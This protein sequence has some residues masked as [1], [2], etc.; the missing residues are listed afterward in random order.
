MFAADADFDVGPRLPSLLHRHLHQ[1]SHALA[2]QHLE[3]IL[4]EDL[5]LH[6]LKE[7][8]TLRVVSRKPEGRLGQIISTKGEELGVLSYLGMQ[9][10]ETQRRPIK[11]SN[12]KI[13]DLY[14][15]NLG[16]KATHDDTVSVV[17]VV[18]RSGAATVQDVL[19]YP[20]EDS[21]LS[22]VTDMIM[23]AD[24]RPASENGRAV[25]S[26][27]VFTFSTILVKN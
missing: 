19:E 12:A 6:I 9:P 5:A 4:G 21:L 10:V 18:N 23:S 14:F 27:L 25:D 3:G 7:E 2:I 26:C 16:Q 8:L 1:L 24:W 20:V 13:N 22:E 17:T 11:P 15:V